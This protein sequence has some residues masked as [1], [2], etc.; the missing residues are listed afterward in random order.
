MPIRV[1]RQLFKQ[2]R[3]RQLIVGLVV[4]SIW[5]G[6]MMVLVERDHPSSRFETMFDGFYWA[7]TTITTVGYG[8]YVPVTVAGKW[9]SIL[10][11]L[12]GAFIFGLVVAMIGSYVDR[13]QDEFYWNR[14][15]ERLDRLEEKFDTLQKRSDYLVKKDVED[16]LETDAETDARKSQNS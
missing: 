16:S 10:L 8:D 13:Y 15:F 4:L 2:R 3:F 5:L 6:M 11:Q 1:R 9:I 7:V 14:L 12:L